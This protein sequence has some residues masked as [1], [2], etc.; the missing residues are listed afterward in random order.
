MTASEILREQ[1]GISPSGELAPV[2]PIAP[3]LPEKGF[4]FKDLV[5]SPTLPIRAMGRVASKVVEKLLLSSDLDRETSRV[6]IP[7]QDSERLL[8]VTEPDP[9]TGVNA[10]EANNKYL[11]PGLAELGD[12]GSAFRLHQRIAEEYPDERIITEPTPGI[13]HSGKI[14]TPDEIANRRIDTMAG[15]SLDY[16]QT[17]TKDGPI[18]GIGTSLGSVILVSMIEQNLAGNNSTRLNIDRATLLSSAVVATDVRED[19]DFREPGIDI[20]AYRQELT[21][22]FKSHVI[23]DALRMA[24]NRPVDIAECAAAILVGYLFH[25]DKGPSRAK[26]IGADFDNVKEGVKW[27]TLRQIV[28][29]IPVK[30]LNGARCPLAQEQK[31]QWGKLSEL[32]PGQVQQR[33]IPGRGHLMTA[34][35]QGAVEELRAMDELAQAA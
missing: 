26:V 23:A 20:Q 17:V 2:I 16:L 18:E 19:E 29:E 31:P 33:L 10:D 1:P 8:L 21:E 24:G 7:Y 11:R 6:V 28:T 32:S 27:N 14:W 15:E 30:V 9:E 35:A 4:S 12:F 34:D 5:P 13:S 22:R 3:S 25:P